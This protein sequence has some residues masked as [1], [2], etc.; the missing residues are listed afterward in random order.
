MSEKKYELYAGKFSDKINRDLKILNQQ[1]IFVRMQNYDYTIWKESPDE[2][3]NR[4]GWLKS[5]ESTMALL[6]EIM[7]FVDDIRRSGLQTILL[8]GMGGSSLAPE[9][10]ELIFGKTNGY[11]DL[12]VLDTTDP[13]AIKKVER[14]LDFT[15][16]LFLVA[17]KS[18]GTVET[19]SLMKYFF[20]RV[21]EA[22]GLKRAGTFFS[23]IT[24]PDSGLEKTG[25]DIELQKDIFK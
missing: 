5:P 10:F 16:T 14:H 1:N 2:I 24:D 7:L 18:G 22:V 4:L 17:T 12:I 20:N 13:D 23:A 9:V 15:Q 19:I 6:P 25:K 11:P 3:T 8:L 21:T